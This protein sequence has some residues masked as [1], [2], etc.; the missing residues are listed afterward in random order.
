MTI[1]EYKAW[2]DGYILGGGKD[3]EVVKA[4]LAEVF[5][6]QIYPLLP[7]PYNIPVPTIQPWDPYNPFIPAG[8]PYTIPFWHTWCGTGTS[9]CDPD[10]KTIA[11]NA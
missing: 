10:I 11:Y 3:V 5:E 4:K 2:F 9:V 1:A 6:F 7:D 8:S